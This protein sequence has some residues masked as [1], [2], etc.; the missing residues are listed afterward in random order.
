MM[1]PMPVSELADEEEIVW[2]EGIDHLPYVREVVY[3]YA[4]FR[5]RPIRWTGSGR[6]VGYSTLRQDARS[7][8]PGWFVRRVFLVQPHDRS[9]QPNG[10]YVTGCPGE[11]VD[12]L[13]VAPGIRGKITRRA[14][15]CDNAPERPHHAGGSCSLCGRSWEGTGDSD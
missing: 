13:T 8:T 3:E 9:E 1:N 5:Q 14:W 12:P 7:R 6:L 2:L 10:T 15:G 11:G 4:N